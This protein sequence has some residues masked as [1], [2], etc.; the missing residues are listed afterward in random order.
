MTSRNVDKIDIKIRREVAVLSAPATLYGYESPEFQ[1]RRGVAR[2]VI[3]FQQ[4]QGKA[5]HGQKSSKEAADKLKTSCTIVHRISG[6]TSSK[7]RHSYIY[8]CN[9]CF[10][11]C[12]LFSCVVVFL[13][14]P[15]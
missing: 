1:C 5:K 10:F 8:I 9:L 7:E 4:V 6:K 12:L 2:I 11:I 3:V 14:F 13:A 15:L